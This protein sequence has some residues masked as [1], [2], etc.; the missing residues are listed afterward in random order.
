MDSTTLNFEDYTRLAH[1][2]RLAKRP[3]DALLVALSIIMASAACG[4]LALVAR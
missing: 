4:C 1:I 2:Y 3:L